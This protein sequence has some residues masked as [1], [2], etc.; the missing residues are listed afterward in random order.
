MTDEMNKFLQELINGGSEEFSNCVGEKFPEILE[1]KLENVSGNAP[2]LN[3]I[4][5]MFSDLC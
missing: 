2:T 5:H 4:Y 1:G 3:K